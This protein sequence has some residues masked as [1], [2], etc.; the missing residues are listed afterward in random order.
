MRERDRLEIDT[1]LRRELGAHL[2]AADWTV[3][4]RESREP[5]APFAGGVL[6]MFARPLKEGFA[7]VVIFTWL[8]E[9]DSPTLDVVAHVGVEYQPAQELL[10]ALTGAE[11]APAALKDPTIAIRVASTSEVSKSA[12]DLSRFASEQAPALDRLADVDVVV[13]LLRQ[14]RVVPFEASTAAIYAM[15]ALD[16]QPG[17]SESVD[18]EDPE[19]RLIPALLASAGRYEEARR[20][21]A[22]HGHLES[23]QARSPREYRRFVRQLTRLLDMGSGFSLPTSPPRWPTCPVQPQPPQSFRQVFSEQR[24]EA[25]TRQEAVDTVRA[26]SK[27]KTRTELRTLL[28]RELD[29]RKASMDTGSFDVTL[30]VLVTEQKRFGRTRLALRAAR[31]LWELGSSSHKQLE[32][33]SKRPSNDVDTEPEA[34]SP[35]MKPPDR[36]AYPIWSIGDRSVAVEL[37]AT[38]RSRLDSVMKSGASEIRDSRF[39][40]VW[41]TWDGGS[42]AVGSHLNV[43]IGTQRVGQLNV[44]TSEHFRPAMEAAADRDEDPWMTARLK[45]GLGE[46]PYVLEIALPEPSQKLASD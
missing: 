39:V 31:A 41:F 45:K 4:G 21:L 46:M 44:D 33:V 34:E 40:D 11:M 16:P 25:R 27:G 32:V 3:R 18:T 7:G 42:P 38:A 29:Q 5:A 6:S 17:A 43:Y 24:P 19:G 36:A 37:D 22:E 30:D 20:E 14:H 12:E 23:E 8:R 13:D 35:L 28:A 2:V 15:S 26:I 1:Q 10:A 9:D